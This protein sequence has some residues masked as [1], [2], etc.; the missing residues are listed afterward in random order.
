M[1]DIIQKIKEKWELLSPELQKELEDFADFL[2]QKYALKRDFRDDIEE[3]T[4]TPT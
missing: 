1:S 2:Y 4:S 3:P